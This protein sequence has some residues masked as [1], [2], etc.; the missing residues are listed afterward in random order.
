MKGGINCTHTGLQRCPKLW[1][2]MRRFFVSHFDK[3]SK[4][5]KPYC[6]GVTI[7]GEIPITG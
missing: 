2:Y 3:M 1:N 5:G 7:P 4:P 6:P